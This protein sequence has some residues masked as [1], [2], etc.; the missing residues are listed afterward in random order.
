MRPLA[1][2]D[3]IFSSAWHAYGVT[4]VHWSRSTDSGRG[5]IERQARADWQTDLARLASA[6]RLM[7]SETQLLRRS[8]LRSFFIFRN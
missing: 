2:G 4:Q 5:L 1:E 3:E 7:E 6:E 8:D